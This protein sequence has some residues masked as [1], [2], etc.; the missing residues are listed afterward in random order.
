MEQ[1]QPLVSLDV[2]DHPGAVWRNLLS[3]TGWDENAN[4]LMADKSIS[5]WVVVPIEFL[6]KKLHLRHGVS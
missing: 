1:A 3:M 6:E 4:P 2:I 5:A